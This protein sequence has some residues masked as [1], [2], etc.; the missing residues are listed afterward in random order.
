MWKELR[1]RSKFFGEIVGNLIID[2]LFFSVW[3]LINIGLQYTMAA[4]YKTGEMPQYIKYPLY[5]FEYTTPVLITFFVI[6]DVICSLKILKDSLM[7]KL[8]GKK[9]NRGKG[10]KRNDDSEE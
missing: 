9:R 2:A 4:L 6:G 5:A 7:D 3:A 8:K 1:E 10:K